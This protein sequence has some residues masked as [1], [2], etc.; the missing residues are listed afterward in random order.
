MGWKET[1]PVKEREKF[2]E[3]YKTGRYQMA[4]LCRIF[5]I[6]R[7]TGYKTVKRVLSDGPAG[8]EDR[9]HAAHS[10]PNATEEDVVKRIIEAKREHMRWGP[11][12]L[13]QLLSNDDPDTE[14]PATSTAGDILKRE[15]LVTPR[16][17]KRVVTHPGKPRVGPI[18]RP[19]ELQNIDF[20]GE[21]RLRNGQ[22]CYPL[23]LTDTFSRKLLLCRGLDATTHEL[24]RAALERHFRDNGL[25]EAIRMDNGCP[26]VISRS[27][28]GLSRLGVWLIKLGIDRVRSR[29]GCPQDNGSHERMHRTMKE[30]TAMPP[31]AD[32]A[33]QQKRFDD[34]QTEFN[35]VRPHEALEGKTPSSLYTPSPLAY[36][37]RFEMYEYPRYFE[38]RAIQAHGGFSWGQKRIFV[39]ESLSGERIGLEE[40]AVGIWSVYFQ[41]ALI[42]VFDEEDG[43]VYGDRRRYQ[44]GS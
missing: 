14:W 9:S 2:V 33:S 11:K 17:A 1:G 38:T 40:T 15:N 41:K 3:M 27:L 29:P 28:A 16:A 31:E 36:P 6:S 37:D 19:N 10:H 26:F 13:I 24:T 12:K 23:T 42:G 30:E 22:W 8:L 25:P 4:T 32:Q 21:F 7:K 43:K 18:T 34:F 35:D 5:G 20:K 39:S 44:L